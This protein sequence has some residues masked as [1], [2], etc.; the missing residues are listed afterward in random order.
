MVNVRVDMLK[1]LPIE[2]QPIE[3]VERKGLGHPDTICDAIVEEVSRA[4][5]KYYLEHYGQILHHNVDKGSLAGGRAEPRFG[6]GEVLEPIYILIIGRATT[7][8]LHEGKLERVPIGTLTLEAA[9]SFLHRSFRFLDP[10]KHVQIDYKI[11]PGSVDLV[12][13]FE[14][15]KSAPLANDTS[16]GVSFAPFSETEKLVLECERYLNSSKVK[17]ELPEVGEDIKVMG[18]REEN[19]IRLT[20][21]AA[22]ISSLTPDLDHYISVKE[23]IKDRILDLATKITTREVEVEVNTADII[24]RNPPLVYLTITGTSAEAGDDGQVG[25]GNRVNGLITPMRP[26]SLEAAAGKNPLSHVGK[27]YNALANLIANRIVEEVQYVKE[28][29]VRILSQIGKPI[30]DPQIASAQ[31]VTDKGAPWNV[32]KS[33]VEGII[34]DEVNKVTSLTQKFVEGKISLY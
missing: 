7:D 9:R 14:S 21:A 26:M 17:K 3:M 22:I 12:T 13:L 19:K 25:R 31:L 28:A 11:R 20:I 10:C 33:D 16:F 30:T 2:E 27:I 23:E 5:C 34:E 1:T 24:D 15:R 32:V 8:V 18:L 29:Y 6:G 4:L